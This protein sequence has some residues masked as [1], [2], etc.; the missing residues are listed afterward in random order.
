MISLSKKS[1]KLL[2]VSVAQ[3]VEYV[4]LNFVVQIVSTLG[5]MSIA[6][7]T[8]MKDAQVKVTN[9]GWK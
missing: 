1:L 6:I 3:R 2:F 4:S 5:R 8:H 9:K 7:K